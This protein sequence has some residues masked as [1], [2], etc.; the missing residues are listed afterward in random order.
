MTEPSGDLSRPSGN[1]ARLD[2]N[3]TERRVDLP[4]QI[5]RNLP[6][7]YYVPDST[8]AQSTVEQSS[9][10]TVARG[11][12]FVALCQL[13]VSMA[14]SASHVLRSNCLVIL[15]K[16]TSSRSLSKSSLQIVQQ[17][18]R[19][20]RKGRP[21]ESV[22]FSGFSRWEFFQVVQVYTGRKPLIP[23]N[24]CTRIFPRTSWRRRFVSSSLLSPMNLLESEAREL[25]SFSLMGFLKKE[26][27]FFSLQSTR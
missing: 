3:A 9:W 13:R 26:S 19:L 1:E 21:C 7:S 11:R 4:L 8:S 2:S 16:L 20:C 18:S 23:R 5:P 15:Q 10:E 6:E 22:S 24:S 14:S 17:K 12:S 25:L 27:N